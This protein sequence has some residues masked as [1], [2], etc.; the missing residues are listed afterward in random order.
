MIIRPKATI[1]DLYGVLSYNVWKTGLEIIKELEDSGKRASS[2]RGSMYV[3]LNDWEEQRLVKS[4]K[5]PHSEEYVKWW[6]E[7]HGDDSELMNSREY[8]RIS[9]GKPKKLFE[10]ESVGG[11]EGSLLPSPA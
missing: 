3:Y 5:R 9:T 7:R 11:L 4:R 1:D 8:S 6:K 10:L 2:L